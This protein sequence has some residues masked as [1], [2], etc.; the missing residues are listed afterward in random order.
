MRD[1]SNIMRDRQRAIRRELDRRGISLKAVSFDSGI[2]YSTLCSYFPGN[3]NGS[4][5]RKPCE[6]PVGAVYSLCGAIPDDLLNLLC[7]E[8]FAVVRVPS[9]IDYD[10]FSAGCREFIEA[11]D[12]AH[13]PE[14]EAGRDIGPNEA[15]DL[16][17]KVIQLRGRV[18]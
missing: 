15:N 6:M 4:V 10:E 1:A 13:H 17:V 12:R 2:P 16:G 8:G 3:E 7:P 14:S 18:A 9:G 11:K 5:E